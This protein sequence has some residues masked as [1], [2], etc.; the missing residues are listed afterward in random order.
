MYIKNNIIN[1]NIKIPS[2]SYGDAPSGS[3][4]IDAVITKPDGSQYLKTTSNGSLT[5]TEPYLD[6]NTFT[7]G[8]FVFSLT[9][10]NTNVDVG[11]WKVEIFSGAPTGDCLRTS[12]YNTAFMTTEHDSEY[13]GTALIGA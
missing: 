9:A 7:D 4:R 10:S 1:F 2:T 13:K 5:Y 6:T 11:L 12:L 3:T 8:S